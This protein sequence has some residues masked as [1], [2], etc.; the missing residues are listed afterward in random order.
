MM[1]TKT[2]GGFYQE[3]SDQ[4]GVEVKALKGRARGFVMGEILSFLAAIACLMMS[5]VPDDNSWRTA[6]WVASVVCMAAYVFVRQRDARNDEQIQ[7][8]EDLRQVYDHEVRAQQGDYACFDDGQRYVDPRHAYTYDLDIFGKDS[9]Y[10]RVC[11]MVTT[12]GCD[13][14]AARLAC[15]DGRSVDHLP[16]GARGEHTAAYRLRITQMAQNEEL[17]AAFI[18]HGVRAKIDTHAI[19]QSLQD[20]AGAKVAKGFAHPLVLAAAVADLLAFGA[21][22]VLAAIGRISSLLPLWWGIGQFFAVYLLCVG[23]LREVSRTVNRLHGQLRQMVG[24]VKLID[25]GKASVFERLTALLD[26]IDRR[27]NVMGLMLVD[28]FALYDLFL[29]RKFLRWREKDK[30][31]MEQW[32]DRVVEMDQD[33][34]VA[35]YLYN[36]PRTVWAEVVDADGV[37][38]EAQKLCHPFLDERAVSN[39]LT[40]EDRHFYLV[41]GANMAGKS[42]FLRSVGINYILARTGIPVCAESL[43]VSRFKL[44]SSMRTSDDLAHG[45]SYFNAELLRLRQLMQSLSVATPSLIILDEILKG[46]NSLDKLNGS[47]LFLEAMARMNVTGVVATHDLELSKMEGERFHNFCFEIQLGENVTYSYKL[48]PGVARNQNATFLLKQLL[49]ESDDGDMAT[50]GKV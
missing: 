13:G 28:T 15:L 5:T 6:A 8:L 10:Q 46:T 1:E 45:I 23:P 49:R 20:A 27:G 47:R 40:V 26:G 50:A 33:V 4:L 16:E 35:T 22:I 18:S 34:T 42:T 43:R 39:S 9:F 36:H 29:V 24:V 11:R 2:L 30:S 3:R 7:R 19:R 37:V 48:T 14:M 31:E 17:R 21:V 44:F 38:F 41:T 12:E 25:D 32:I